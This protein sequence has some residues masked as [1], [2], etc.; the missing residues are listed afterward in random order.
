MTNT[1]KA[2]AV[3]GAGPGVG[4]AVARRYG[5]AG[6][7]VVL[8]ARRH[9][10]LDE[11]AGELTAQGVTAHVVTGDLSDTERV[12]DLAARIRAKVGD[13]AA[14]YYGPAT[15][16][17]FVAAA[18]LRAER[19]RALMPMTLYTLV[20]L[21]REFLPA[22]LDRG[23]GAILSAQ[24]AAAVH[25]LP[26]MSGWTP[27]LAAQRH[28]LQSLAA[29]VADRGVYVG[30]LYI[31]ARILGTPYEARF[32]ELRAAGEPVL[33]LPAAD[34]G[35]LAELLWTMHGDRKPEEKVVPEGLFDR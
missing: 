19:L 34:P 15:D 16:P 2:I 33:D 3:F 24:G 20:E 23:D 7:E 4:R 25:G 22:M 12:P 6:Y 11:F 28:Y 13:P 18:D 14:V 9:G 30:M 32:Q 8:V 26:N 29:E 1:H 27:A 17:D 35:E 10:P 21:V 31:G 5:K